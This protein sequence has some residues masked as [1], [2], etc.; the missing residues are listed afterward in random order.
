MSIVKMKKMYLAVQ[1]NDQEKTLDKL[2][3]LGVLHVVPVDPSTAVATDDIVLAQEQLKRAIQILSSITAEGEKTL[4]EVNDAIQEI[5]E[6]ERTNAELENRLNA[7]HRQLSSQAA[8]GDTKL[9]DIDYLT[10][11]NVH[12]CF[13]TTKTENVEKLNASFVQVINETGGK[14]LVALVSDCSEFE[15][16]ETAE[17]I[18]LPTKDNPTIKAEAAQIEKTQLEN[19]EKLKCLAYML[20]QLKEHVVHVDE[21]VSFSQIS[22]S[23]LDDEDIFAI[24]GWVPDGAENDIAPAFEAANISAGIDIYEPTEDDAP[25]TLLKIPNWAK[26]IEG[27]FSVLGT[28]SG[29]KEFDVSIPFMLALPIFA[30]ILI[31][32]GAYGAILLF[33]PMLAFKKVSKALGEPFTKLLMVIGGVTLVWGFLCGS[34]FGKLIYPNPLIPVDMTDESR[35]LMMNISFTMGA[36]HLCCAKLW[37]VVRE[38]PSLRALCS[39]GWAIFIWGMYGVVKMFVMGGTLG[40]DTPWPYF[41]IAGAALAIVFT[42]PNKNVV[43]MLAIGLASFPLDMLSAF[44]DIISYVR[45][46]AV[47]LAS[48]VLAQSFNELG[49]GAGPIMMVPILVLGHSLNL[50]LAIIA[51]FAHGVRLN[52][53]EFSNNLGMQWVGCAYKP[54]AKQ[55][56]QEK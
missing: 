7:L 46:M 37:Q 10:D 43:K 12:I 6:V 52:M 20:E 3:E 53:L 4:L 38:A 51:L 54:F 25:P 16:P 48:G 8:W 21:K 23:A 45:L 27:L 42:A 50:G 40:M 56:I 36:I 26:P 55:T 19:T 31:G 32:D 9:A 18:L 24:Q 5:L 47:G 22:N 41:L 14:A 39:L 28:V 49:M 35:N 2:H 29:Y 17:P 33:G 13:V 15:L 34:F 30:A 1:K 44:S 11:A